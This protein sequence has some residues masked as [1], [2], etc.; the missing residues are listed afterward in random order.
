[1]DL[2]RPVG[3]SYVPGI[4]LKDGQAFTH[5]CVD[6]PLVLLGKNK[7]EGLHVLHRS[8][9]F[10]LNSHQ[11][12]LAYGHLKPIP[13]LGSQHKKKKLQKPQVTQLSETATVVL[14]LRNRYRC[15]ISKKPSGTVS[16]TQ[17]VFSLS[18]SQDRRLFFSFGR[19]KRTRR[20]T[21]RMR[22]LMST[23]LSKQ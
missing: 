14:F 23:L 3:G 21:R 13:G 9:Y 17:K 7:T 12:T 11:T 4:C 16:L 18:L 15:F 22:N 5:C 19:M 8:F 2:L 20:K 6:V 1:M 10:D